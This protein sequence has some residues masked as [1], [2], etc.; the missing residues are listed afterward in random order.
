M[1]NKGIFNRTKYIYINKELS[2]YTVSKILQ[3]E[4]T[5]P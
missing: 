5:A 3:D 4:Q 1:H 2:Y